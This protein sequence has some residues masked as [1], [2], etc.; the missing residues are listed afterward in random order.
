MLP[1]VQ[2][3]ITNYPPKAYLKHLSFEFYLPNAK[4]DTSSNESIWTKGPFT[5]RNLPMFFDFHDMGEIRHGIL[6]FQD[7]KLTSLN[8]P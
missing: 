7:F 3:F 8:Y 6:Y 4:N 2:I 1:I 5:R